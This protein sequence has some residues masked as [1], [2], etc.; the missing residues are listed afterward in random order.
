MYNEFQK[1][2]Y[3]ESKDFV[4]DEGA[5][6]V[7]ERIFETVSKT[8]FQKDKDLSEYN[9]LQVIDLLKNVNSKSKNYL[10][11]VSKFCFEYTNWQKTQGASDNGSPNYYDYAITKDIIDDL[12]PLSMIQDKYFTRD[13]I[14][15][16]VKNKIKDPMNRFLVYAPFSAVCG[17]NCDNL[18]YLKYSDINVKEKTVNLKSGI[19]VGVDDL[20]IELARAANETI[21]YMP[22][23][24]SEMDTARNSKMFLYSGSNYIVKSCGGREKAEDV[25]TQSFIIQRFKFIQKQVENEFI[26]PSNLYKNGLI[27]FIKERFEEEGVTLRQAF[28]EK[29]DKINYVHSG[30]LTKYIEEY[31]SNLN[32]RQL[33]REIEEVISLYE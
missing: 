32:I 7:A 4:H 29:L 20:F 12:V 23:G 16:V 26:T 8:E 33:R 25:V 18:K 22:E 6:E 3:L 17:A 28:F 31:G 27:N 1:K 21:E 14:I 5:K 9:K 19:T 10:R 11:L 30:K 24:V 13:Y 2:R 15:N